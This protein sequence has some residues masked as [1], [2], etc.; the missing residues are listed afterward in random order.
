[1]KKHQLFFGHLR[2]KYNKYTN[3]TPEYSKNIYALGTFLNVNPSH[4]NRE[5]FQLYPV[6]TSIYMFNH[7][8]SL[9]D[10][11]EFMES[12]NETSEMYTSENRSVRKAL[13]ELFPNTQFS[14][15]AEGAEFLDGV[16]NQNP[17]HTIRLIE[18]IDDEYYLYYV[19]MAGVAPL[20]MK[21]VEL[22]NAGNFGVDNDLYFKDSDSTI[23][24]KIDSINKLI[25]G[26]VKDYFGH[27]FSYSDI[28]Q[29]QVIEPF[30]ING[31]FI[32]P[33]NAF[34]FNSTTHSPS[35]DR[36][37]NIIKMN[38]KWNPLG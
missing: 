29:V 10:D 23:R 11:K 25:L 31:P 12:Y 1:M 26:M 38:K 19:L 28:D 7:L 9:I 22:A 27:Q 36:N 5:R 8:R 33:E 35:P 37:V 14:I 20:E 32:N 15:S 13:K 4:M 21:N 17:E 24:Y 2:N 6:D 16:G 30:Y 18:A 34:V 3:L